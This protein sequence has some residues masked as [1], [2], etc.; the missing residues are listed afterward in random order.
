MP[1][2]KKVKKNNEIP[3]YYNFSPQKLL[4]IIQIYLIK[5]FLT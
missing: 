2:N 1:I 4:K 5:Q 3:K